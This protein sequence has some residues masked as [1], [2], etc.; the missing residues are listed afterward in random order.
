MIK[1]MVLISSLLFSS[2]GF[3]NDDKNEQFIVFNDSISF[4]INLSETANL[5]ARAFYEK[6]NLD[7]FREVL[8]NKHSDN[9]EFKKINMAIFDSAEKLQTNVSLDAQIILIEWFKN[10]TLKSCIENVK[11]IK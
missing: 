7:H 10:I 1:G 5:A 2:V 3:A 11:S 4:C 8:E 6:G 9:K